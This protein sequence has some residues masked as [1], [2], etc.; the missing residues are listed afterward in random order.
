MWT[1]NISVVEYSVLVW[2]NDTYILLCINIVVNIFTFPCTYMMWG[3]DTFGLHCTDMMMTNMTFGISLYY[4]N[5]ANDT[6]GFTLYTL[7]GE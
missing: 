2:A 1:T 5:G 3:K 4:Y 6:F 7:V